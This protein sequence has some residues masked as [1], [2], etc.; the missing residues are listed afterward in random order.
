MKRDEDAEKEGHFNRNREEEAV[1][2]VNLYLK[3]SER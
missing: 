3:V 2:W 1:E